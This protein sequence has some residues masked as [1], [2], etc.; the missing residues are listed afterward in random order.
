MI[1]LLHHQNIR[2]VTARLLLDQHMMLQALVRRIA[3]KGTALVKIDGPYGGTST[4]ADGHCP[5]AVVFA[6]GI[7]VSCSA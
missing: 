4:L 5:V 2:N 3:D 1:G 6:G 7:G